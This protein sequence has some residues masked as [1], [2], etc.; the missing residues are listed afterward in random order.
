M[1]KA[2]ITDFIDNLSLTYHLENTPC[3]IIIWDAQLRVIY[4]S[5]RAAEIF[6]WDLEEVEYPFS[7]THLIFEED[8]PKVSICIEEITSGKTVHNTCNNRNYTNNGKVIYCQWYNSALKDEAGNLVNILS[9]VQDVT[10]QKQVEFELEK[11]QQQLSLIYNS[12]IDPMW[13]IA[14]EGNNRFRFETINHSFMEVTGLTKE[15]VI[16]L[17]IEQVMPEASHELV[18]GKYNEAIN[19]GKIIDYVEE[20][21]HPAGTKYGEIRVIPIKDHTGQVTK[22]LGIAN[23]ITEKVMLQKKLDLERD[24][25]NR[26]ITKAAVKGQEIERA[27]VSRELHDNVNQVLTTIKLYTELCIAGKVDIEEVLP[28]CTTLLNDTITEI[29][30]LSKE[31]SAPSLGDIGLKET[32]TDLVES[33]RIAKEIDIKL[34]ILVD[35][36]TVIDN[37]LHLTLYRIVQEQLT[38]ILKHAD[39][40]SVFVKL[41]E[42]DSVLTLIIKDNGKGFNTSQKVTGIGITNMRSRAQMLNGSLE[43]EST[44][45]KGVCLK[46]S[47]PVEVVGGKC[48]PAEW[49]E[50]SSSSNN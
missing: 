31:L 27:K 5:A 28:K 41:E 19:T 46:A 48:M 22:L 17:P 33:I 39:A 3:G 32:L 47:F 14:V 34:L 36:N 44:E 2:G 29:R 24:S 38:N 25:K 8:N 40:R 18:R 20:A 37:E 43:I 11:S 13:L 30:S 49:K 12:A 7:F 9:L 23:D 6:E 16:G 45:G 21:V 10:E 26:Q 42:N 35:C 15:K 1:S 4:S 50:R